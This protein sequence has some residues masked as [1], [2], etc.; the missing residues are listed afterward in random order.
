MC[1][2]STC[3]QPFIIHEYA[4]LNP[5]IYAHTSACPFLEANLLEEL[6]TLAAKARIRRM[7]KPKSKRSDLAAPDYIVKYWESGTK[8][9]DELAK[10]LKDCNWVRVP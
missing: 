4:K 8:G 9:K 5:P 2:C 7:V 3:I 1:I 6:L 10:I